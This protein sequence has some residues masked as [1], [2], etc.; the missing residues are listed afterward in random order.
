M[1]REFRSVFLFFL[2]LYWTQTG[3]LAGRTRLC[4]TWCSYHKVL[5]LP[6]GRFLLE[7]CWCRFACCLLLRFL[8]SRYTTV[9][10]HIYGRIVIAVVPCFSLLSVLPTWYLI[11]Y[12]GERHLIMYF[13]LVSIFPFGFPFLF[14]DVP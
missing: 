9:V 11:P 13:V 8:F 10:V 3:P 6:E 2:L 4:Y 7:L 12:R 5:R 1:Y 14:M